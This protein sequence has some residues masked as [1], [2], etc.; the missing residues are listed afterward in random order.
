MTAVPA[1]AHP[2]LEGHT[3]DRAGHPDCISKCARPSVT[4]AYVGYYVGGGAVG[5]KA[6]PPLASDGTWGWDYQGGWFRRRVI[7]NWWHGR[8]YQGGIGAYKTDGPHLQH[9]E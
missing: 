3:M 7:L 6:E 1:L 9:K 2:P 5:P 8:R 4:P